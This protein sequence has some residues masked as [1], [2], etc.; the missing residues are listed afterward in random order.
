MRK[1]RVPVGVL[2]EFHALVE[3][4][5]SD[6]DFKAS[7]QLLPEEEKKEIDLEKAADLAKLYGIAYMNRFVESAKK[8]DTPQGFDPSNFEKQMSELDYTDRRT[9]R[10]V[11]LTKAELSK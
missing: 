8:L 9:G 10:E 5:R 11:Y 1:E 3:A 6:D 2:K 4:L 7:F